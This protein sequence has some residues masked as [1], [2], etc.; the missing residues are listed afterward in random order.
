MPVSGRTVRVLIDENCTI[1][2][3]SRVL[4]KLRNIVNA[5]E[6]GFT[7]PMG[8]QVP[9]SLSL[10]VFPW[11]FR[12]LSPSL[13]IPLSISPCTHNHEPLT[14]YPEPDTLRNKPWTV[15]RKP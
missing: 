9:F 14:L 3:D 1:P 4:I 2:E 7:A 6:Y 12:Y 5:L 10:P 11:E 13:S 15:N 8:I